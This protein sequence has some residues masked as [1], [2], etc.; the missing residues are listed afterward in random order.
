MPRVVVLLHRPV[1]CG[2]GSVASPGC[3]EGMLKSH[4]YLHTPFQQAG[5][6]TD[7]VPQTRHSLSY[8]SPVHSLGFD[9]ELG[10]ALPWLVQF[11]QVLP[12]HTR[13][14]AFR[15]QGWTKTRT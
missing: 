5:E 9:H 7:P 1:G 6:V 15:A 8:D 11:R 2:P 3:W 14:Y 4:V 12:T 10:S 13:H